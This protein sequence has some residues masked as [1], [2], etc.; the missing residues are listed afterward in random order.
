VV[1]RIYAKQDKK[2]VKPQAGI[3]R[4]KHALKEK[5]KAYRMPL[6]TSAAKAVK[7]LKAEAAAKKRINNLLTAQRIERFFL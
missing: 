2:A 6:L 7:A 4:W 3:N 5:A 1:K